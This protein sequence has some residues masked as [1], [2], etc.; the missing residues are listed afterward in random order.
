MRG[1]K[2]TGASIGDVDHVLA[3]LDQRAADRQVVDGMAVVLGIDDGGRFGGEPREV[4]ADG[5]AADIDVGVE[6]SLERDR[7]RDLAGADQ[8]AREFEDLLMDRLEEMLRL[9]KVRNAVEGLVVDQ[10]SAQQRLFRLDIV[11]SGTI[12]RRRFFDL[13]AGSRIQRG[14]L[15]V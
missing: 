11:R 2:S 6:E 5:E 10:D 9:E 4:L 12:G 15:D 7:R 8:V 14:P 3:D 1:E 13:L